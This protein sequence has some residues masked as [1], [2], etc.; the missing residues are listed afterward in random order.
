MVIVEKIHAFC[1][2][3][4]INEML[5]KADQRKKT[6]VNFGSDG[7][8]YNGFR[9]FSKAQCQVFIDGKVIKR[10]KKL[11]GKIPSLI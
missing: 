8:T 11:Y 10:I 2:E 3:K 9:L 1:N 5:E 4:G 6:R 7:E